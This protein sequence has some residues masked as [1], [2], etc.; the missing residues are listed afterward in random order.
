[1]LK[2]E[3]FC[4]AWEVSTRMI[5]VVDNY[6]SFVYN[7]VQY[8]GT[9]GAE[10]LVVRNDA[11]TLEEIES[12]RPQAVIISP[13]PCSPSEA[14]ISVPLVRSLAGR[15]PILGICLGHQAIAQAFGA[16]VRRAVRPM[17]GKTSLI[18]HDGSGCLHGLPVPLEVCRYHSL[19]VEESTLPGDLQVT[20]RSPDGEIMAL[21]HSTW[22]VEGLQFH[23]ESIFTQHGLQ[24]MA[25]Y[26]AGL[27]VSAP[28][29]P[30]STPVLV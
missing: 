29:G 15:I 24:I 12:L 5:L 19:A 30:R 13:G 9:L 3:H 22:P 2:P 11:C 26:L 1:M 25:N 20:A 14:G 21:R 7:L 16:T 4:Y 17:H 8:V 28:P 10:T 23:P 27:S 18:W 6:D